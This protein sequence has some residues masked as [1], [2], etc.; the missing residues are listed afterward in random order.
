MAAK[1]KSQIITNIDSKIIAK[2][3]ISAVDTNAILKDILD[4]SDKPVAP[5]NG[6]DFGNLDNPL[7]PND[8]MSVKMNFTGIEKFS[9]SLYLCVETKANNSDTVNEKK[10]TE[11]IFVPLE[12]EQ[13][14]ILQSF[15]PNINEREMYLTF[16]V[17]F[18]A[19]QTQ[20]TVE[21]PNGGF[22]A[23]RDVAMSSMVSNR[24]STYPM[25]I[26]G[27]G[28]LTDI[29]NQKGVHLILPDSGH[30]STS[31]TL[32]YKSNRFNLKLLTSEMSKGLEKAFESIIKDNDLDTTNNL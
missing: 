29:Q 1:T 23:P 3:N 17:P 13:F 2:G 32:S 28:L 8:S 30:I 24:I 18:L 27:L 6:F 16:V 14:K 31:V 4:F 12:D 15:L 26:I 21:N 7:R 19:T 11:W 10:D 20:S 22:A 9:C 5:T 25:T